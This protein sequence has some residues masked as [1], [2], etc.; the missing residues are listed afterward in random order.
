M[1]AII[2]TLVLGLALFQSSRQ[3][4]GTD[5]EYDELNGQ[6]WI[7]R[8]ESEELRANP[9]RN[10]RVIEKISVYDVS[11]RLTG[12]VL[13]FSSDCA[14]SRHVFSHDADGNR[15]EAVYWGKALAAD[16]KSDPSQSPSSPV[17]YKQ[18]FKL[19]TA[20]RRSEVNEY[21]SAGRLFGKSVY[22]YDDQGRVKEITNGKDSRRSHCEL[23]YNDRGLA[24]ERTCQYSYDSG[25]DKSEY[26]YEYDTN[27]NWVKKTAKN[28]SRRPDGSSY[29][30]TKVTY[31]EIKYYSSDDGPKQQNEAGDRFDIWKLAPCPPMIIR[32][33]GGVLQ[34]SATK[35]AEPRYP[36]EAIAARIAGSVVVEV[37]VDE[38][39]KVIS[40]RA[41]SGTPELYEA[42]VAAARRWEFHPTT[43]SKVPVKVIG[44]ITFNYN[45]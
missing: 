45:L 31:R 42:S 5:R 12:E 21:D 24:S 28:S 17:M 38:A 33:S 22:R 1:H 40:A 44:T 19:D 29:E 32:K 25:R 14:S 41:I 4:K 30:S 34:G 7:V 6:V 11:G 23:K 13:S 9:K 39:G 18:V 37:V 8:I 35:R 36:S 10:A 2:G 43:L 20:G 26:A 15:T 3:A 16:G 27:G